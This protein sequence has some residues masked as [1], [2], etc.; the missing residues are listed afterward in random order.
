MDKTALFKVSYGLYV[1]GVRNG[2]SFGGSVVDAFMQTSDTPC[3]AALSS[4]KTSLTC[5]L[6]GKTGELMLSVLPQNVDPLIIANFGFQSARKVDKWANVAHEVV[7]GLPRLACAC[8][9]Y[10][11]KV[12]GSRE[13]PTHM[14]YFLDVENAWQGEGAPLLYADYQAKMKPAAMSAFQTLLAKQK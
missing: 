12:V 11:L 7:E 2:Q 3:T 14:L 9:S 10:R 8:A 6:I 13:L 4:M 1:A 5:E